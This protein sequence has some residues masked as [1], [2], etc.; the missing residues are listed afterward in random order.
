MDGDLPEP[1]CDRCEEL[2]AIIAALQMQ[3]KELTA[4]LEKV[5]REGKRQGAPFRKKRK[6]DPKKPGRNSGEDHGHHHRRAVPKKIDETYDAPLPAC[7]PDC[8]YGQL[9]KTETLVQ[10]Q[11]DIPRVVVHRRFNIE[12]GTCGGCGSHLQGR[13]EL[14]TSDAVGAAAVQLGPN[15]HAAMTLLNKELG[16]S[17]GKVKRL[18]EMLFEIRISRSTSCRSMLR[19]ADRLEDADAQIRRAVRGSP[20]VVGDET[21]WR[22]DG[23]GAWLHA[24]VGL[25]AT[26][27]E[28]DASRGIGPAERLLGIDWSGIFG[29]DRWAVY[30]KFTSATH[31]QCF[32]HLLRRCDRLVESGTGGA[33]AFPRGVKKVLLEGS[34]YRNRFRLDGMTAHGM[35]VLA[36]RLTMQMWKLVRHRKTNA[37]NERFAKFL[38]KHLNDLFTFLRHPG[39]DATNWRG[40]QAIRP[41]VVNRKVWGGNRTVVGALAQSRIM[42]VMQTCKQRMADPFEFIRRQLTATT[43]LAL[44]LPI[45]AQ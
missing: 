36:G 41:A 23:R 17:H 11:T 27:Y 9:T 7:C 14:Q 33:L 18:L 13:H 45:T 44:P 35:K 16:L 19:T 40:E 26:C 25:T 29:H 28:V 34:E 21:G 42:S 31:Q 20:Q 43:P 37:S 32:A 2:L 39:A 10:F 24:F 12:V 15:V 38:E 30:D 4:R 1:K 5:E 3:V 8:G 22:V 6:A